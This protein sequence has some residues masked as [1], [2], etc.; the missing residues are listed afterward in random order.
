[1]FESQLLLSFLPPLLSFHL[2]F[3]CEKCVASHEWS[4][5]SIQQQ[6]D[7]SKVR[8][9]DTVME[10]HIP[11]SICQVNNIRQ[12]SGGG[13]PH[14]SQVQSDSVGLGVLLTGDSEPL[15]IE[16]HQNLPL[17]KEKG[18]EKLRRKSCQWHHFL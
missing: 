5:T 3:F 16:R 9:G 13:Q 2:V 8:V 1:M 18:R 4:L 10:R 7:D 17:Q 15:L 12:Q 14:L 6:F 11:I